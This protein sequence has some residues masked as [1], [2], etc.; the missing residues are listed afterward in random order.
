MLDI[1]DPKKREQLL[2]V[3][4]GIILCGILIG[5]LPG[6]FRAVA[7]LKRQRSNLEDDIEEHKRIARN[8]EE[9]QGRL[10]AMT[11]QALASA[12]LADESRSKYENWLMALTADSGMR[13]YSRTGYIFS[14][15]KDKD[16]VLYGKHVLTINGTG[17]LEQIAEFMRRFHRTEFLHIIQ[18]VPT[19]RPVTTQG[20]QGEFDAT[21]KIEVL[22]LPQVSSINELDVSR[23]ATAISSDE[24]RMLA[25]IRERQ[26]LSQYTPTPPPPP[27]RVTG[28]TV[29]SVT[30]TWTSNEDANTYDIRYK[31][32]ADANVPANWTLVDF[33]G[34]TGT[35][36]ELTEGTNYDFQIRAVNDTGP[37]AWSVSVAGA[38]MSQPTPPL[39]LDA[40]PYCVLRGIVEADGKPGCWIYNQMLG[41]R[42]YASEGETFVLSTMAGGTNTVR[43]TVKKI[44]VNAGRVHIEVAGMVSTIKNGNSFGMSEIPSCFLTEIV[45]VDGKLVCRIDY[46]TKGEKHELALGDSFM[47][48]EVSCTVKSIDKATN[49]IQIEAAG[50]VYTIRVGGS[51]TEFANE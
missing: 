31:R 19:L 47:M 37:A 20:R 33:E 26:I 21:I 12:P 43:C 40:I 7:D 23:E 50:V 30:L 13:S 42:F 10:T 44:E 35:I 9:I 5:V 38:T 41:E 16:K 49:R 34:T 14:V 17:R 24:R 6:Q 48:R 3:V 15:G 18:S 45:E 11:G 25:N 2:V 32:S 39:T 22:S 1:S 46:R 27:I 4:A 29:E 36:R 28:R 51:F 8:K